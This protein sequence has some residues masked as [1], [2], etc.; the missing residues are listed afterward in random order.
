MLREAV[1]ACRIFAGTFLA[2]TCLL[3]VAGLDWFLALVAVASFSLIVLL[4]ARMTAE[5]GIPW[6][7]NFSGVASVL[8]MKLLGSAAL[9]PKG[10]AVMALVGAVMGADMSNSVAA[11]ETTIS[12]LAE[13]HQGRSGRSLRLLLLLGVVLAICLTVISTLWDNYSF[14]ARQEKTLSSALRSNMDSASVE[15]NRLQIEKK[16]GEVPVVRGL[17]KFGQVKSEPNFWRFFLYGTL[18]V[19]VCALMRLRFTWWPFH[20]LPLLL[21]GTWCL[22][23]L[24][25]SILIGWLIKVA[26][27]KIGGGRVFSQSKPFFI[28]VIVGHIVAAALWVAVAAIYYLRTGAQPPPLN[29]FL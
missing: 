29:F 7:V 22:S 21:I 16:G 20:P 1:V 19:A 13:V 26:L 9:G 14:G 11:Q 2:L 8:P 4:A 6:L 17:A 12:K 15:I 28:G 10:L 3:V 18:I 23:R 24:Y 27:V 5:I 25:F